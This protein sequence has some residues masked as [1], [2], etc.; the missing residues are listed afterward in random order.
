MLAWGGGDRKTEGLSPDRPA[1]LYHRVRRP[2]RKTKKRGRSVR[3]GQRRGR[4]GRDGDE[5][6]DDDCVCVTWLKVGGGGG[7]PG[8][9]GGG[10]GMGILLLLQPT[11]DHPETHKHSSLQSV[12]IHRNQTG[13]RPPAP[14]L[15]EDTGAEDRGRDQNYFM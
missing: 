8:G 11:P 4:R 3:V 13:D 9:G 2:K 6:D 12:S 7:P 15:T 1:A 5:G 14:P 10:G